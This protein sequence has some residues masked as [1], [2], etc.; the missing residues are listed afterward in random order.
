M[1]IMGNIW[2]H[3][4]VDVH[5]LAALYHSPPPSQVEKRVGVTLGSLK[6]YVEV[7]MGRSPTSSGPCGYEI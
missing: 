2:E 6:V 4:D 1:E 3:D 7:K 5:V